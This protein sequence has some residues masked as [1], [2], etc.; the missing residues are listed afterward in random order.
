MS[1]WYKKDKTLVKNSAP[2]WIMLL[3]KSPY[4]QFVITDTK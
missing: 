3:Y 1:L 4:L 2:L